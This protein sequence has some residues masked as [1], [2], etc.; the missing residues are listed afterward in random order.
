V[1]ST[2]AVL[3]GPESILGCNR[4]SQNEPQPRPP[5]LRRGVS[6]VE[7]LVSR[8]VQAAQPLPSHGTCGAEPLVSR[9]D[10]CV[11]PL[12]S[13]G[14]ANPQVLHGLCNEA[15]IRC[16]VRYVEHPIGGGLKCLEPL[17]GKAANL[18]PQSALI[19]GG[20]K[21]DLV[22]AALE[23]QERF[24]GRARR[25]AFCDTCTNFI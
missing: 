12:V 13:Q 17:P 1:S 14:Y 16:K 2:F 24:K 11:E 9:R 21:K 20:S 6:C 4:H 22:A 15:Q 8:G 7:P 19:P 25:Y 10:R 3:S 23:I 18:R 5:I